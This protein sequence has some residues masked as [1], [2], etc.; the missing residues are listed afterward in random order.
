MAFRDEVD[1][2]YDDQVSFERR[3]FYFLIHFETHVQTL[4]PR[5]RGTT[6]PTRDIP[7]GRNR[8]TSW[9]CSTAAPRRK[10]TG[11]PSA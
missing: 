4:A 8:T 9:T 7:S 11:R 6:R 2:E 5:R 1:Y 3:A 10:A